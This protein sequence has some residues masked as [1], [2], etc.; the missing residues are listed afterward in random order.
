MSDIRL[1]ENAMSKTEKKKKWKSRHAS[2]RTTSQE[3]Y[4]YNVPSRKN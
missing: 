4:I 1:S 2:S 3:L